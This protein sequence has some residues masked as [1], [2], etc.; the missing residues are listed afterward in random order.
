MH[1]HR[2]SM[3]IAGCGLRVAVSYIW[4]HWELLGCG[5]LWTVDCGLWTVDCGLWTVDCGL[6]CYGYG[7]YDMVWDIWDNG[8]GRRYHEID[9][10]VAV[11]V[12]IAAAVEIAVAV[13]VGVGIMV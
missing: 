13:E 7:G 9:V 4:W 12:E 10:A 8:A 5:G 2:Y 6:W 1:N 11:A 3:Y